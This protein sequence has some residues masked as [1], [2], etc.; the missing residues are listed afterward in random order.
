MSADTPSNFDKRTVNGFG[1]EWHA[2]DQ[3]GLPDAEAKAH[4]DAY[5][6][7]FRWEL[8]GPQSTGFDMGC[9]SGRWAK[10]LAPRIGHLHCIDPSSALEVARRNLAD[11][12]NVSFHQALVDAA[13]LAPGSMDFGISL[14]VL[15]HVPDT[16]AAIRSCAEMLK[17]GAPLLLYLYYRFDNQPAW[18]RVL[19]EISELGR[20]LISRLPSAARVAV[21]SV[22]AALIYWPLSRLTR[23]CAAL[24]V[25]TKSLPL[26]YYRDASFYTMRTDALDRFGTNLEQR[27]TRKEITGMLTAAGC[28]EIRFSDKMPYWC[29][30]A[31]RAH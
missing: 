13:P 14:G 27:F 26:S 25:N 5:F 12:P 29:V 10:L 4:F 3:T 31:V 17:P 23:L 1:E 22:I 24:G 28:D 15:H 2:F 8:V 16:G 18:Y 11:F 9:G 30:C 20:R 6:A 7:P 19:W 21:T